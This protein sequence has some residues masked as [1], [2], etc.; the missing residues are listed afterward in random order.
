MSDASEI[1]MSETENYKD[2]KPESNITVSEA[3][4]YLEEIFEKV[5]DSS[6]NTLGKK[7]EQVENVLEKKDINEIIKEY[8]LDLK[9]K[10]EFSNTIPD[11]TF[12]KSDLKKIS[13]EEN[14]KM[15]EEF[16]DKKELLREQWE[17]K[18]GCSWP[19]YKHDI[20][21]EKGNLLRRAGDPYDIHH[22]QSL[23]M[24]GKNEVGN[25]T[26]LHVDVHYDKKGVHAKESPYDKLSK[27]IGEKE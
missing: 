18:H 17:K 14:A 7:E 22:I 16:D 5:G 13:P 19:I 6:E 24:G 9:E 4:E 15:R 20:Y 12:K 2:I 25:I 23:E 1:K 8:F 10:S 26:P 21:S 3:R 11:K 27:M